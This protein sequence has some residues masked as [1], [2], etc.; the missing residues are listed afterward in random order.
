MVV[1]CPVNM[2]LSEVPPFIKVDFYGFLWL[3]T[4]ETYSIEQ[5]SLHNLRY[6][7]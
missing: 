2:S 3:R 5:A 6:W 1:A 7:Q 4:K